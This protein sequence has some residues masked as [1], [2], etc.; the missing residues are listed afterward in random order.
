MYKRKVQG[1]NTI[2]INILP[3]WD[4]SLTNFNFNPFIN[5]NPNYLNDE[6]FEH[7]KKMCEKAKKEGFELSLVLLWCNYVPGTWA[8]SL[9]PDGV[10]P[11]DCLKNY[12][13]KVH[14]TFSKF[15]PLYIVSGD[16]DFPTQE[17]IKYYAYVAS[18]LKKLAP[19]CL[20][21]THIKGRYTYIPKEIYQ[22]LDL[23]FIKVDT[24]Q[25][26]YPCH[27]H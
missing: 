9:I 18:A 8:S 23:C 27:I 21:T 20:L 12:V 16:T 10:L 17:S 26:I 25:K 24:M 7:A 15:E 11:F 5:N 22:Y 3:Q 4:A 13:E 1:F 6:Y 19:S 14:E 2:Q